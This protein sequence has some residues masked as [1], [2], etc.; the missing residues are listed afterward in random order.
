MQKQR[1]LI[2]KC[3]ELFRGLMHQDAHEFLNYL[4]NEIAESIQKQSKKGKNNQ[5]MERKRKFKF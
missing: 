4:L 3:K 1:K 2:K 5:K